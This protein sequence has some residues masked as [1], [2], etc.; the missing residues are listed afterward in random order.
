MKEQNKEPEWGN[1]KN[2]LNFHWGFLHSK[3]QDLLFSPMIYS[4][5]G[6]NAFLLSYERFSQKGIHRFTGATNNTV[7]KSGAP[8]IS[9][10][11]FGETISRLD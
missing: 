4:G 1:T 9:F 6:L 5:G 2:R 10:D 7:I 8:D 3:Q 11:L